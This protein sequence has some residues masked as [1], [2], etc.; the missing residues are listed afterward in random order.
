MPKTK[1]DPAMETAKTLGDI[2][3][4][5]EA[6]QTK[7]EQLRHYEDLRRRGVLADDD[8]ISISHKLDELVFERERL[9]GRMRVLQ[10][11]IKLRVDAVMSDPATQARRDAI[12]SQ[13]QTTN[14]VLTQAT[15][16]LDQAESALSLFRQR[17][18]D[19][20]LDPEFTEKRLAELEIDIE[21]KRRIKTE[22]LDALGKLDERVLEM[23]LD[24][25]GLSNEPLLRVVPANGHAAILKSFGVFKAVCHP[26]RVTPVPAVLERAARA[27]IDEGTLV[28]VD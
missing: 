21:E 20:N 16:D 28:A 14:A 12:R 18:E 25:L 4:T 22:T 10:N 9:A 26:G 15:I 8:G 11:E 23:R 7:G 2:N 3:E 24:A 19:G 5:R 6:I 17:V 13:V 1:T 27:L